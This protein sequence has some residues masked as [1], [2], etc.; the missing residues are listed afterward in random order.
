MKFNTSA[1]FYENRSIHI[2]K[3]W[4]KKEKVKKRK[5]I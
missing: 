4:V 2:A 1:Y 5:K 3:V